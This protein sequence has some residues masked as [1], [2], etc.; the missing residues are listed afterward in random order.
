MIYNSPTGVN[1]FW[2]KWQR[3]N[4]VET[5]YD[6]TKFID[7]PSGKAFVGRV[8]PERYTYYYHTLE[9]EYIV[10]D[11][12]T[13]CPPN[14]R[15][16]SKVYRIGSDTDVPDLVKLVPAALGA[17]IDKIYLLTI[18][19]KVK[20]PT[21]KALF[22]SG[23]H[24]REP[25]GVTSLIAY[26]DYIISTP[27]NKALDNWS[28]NVVLLMN[29]LGYFIDNNRTYQLKKEINNVEG[30][31]HRKNDRNIKVF[32]LAKLKDPVAISRVVHREVQE[33]GRCGADIPS[34]LELVH[35]QPRAVG[36]VGVDLNRNSG[37]EFQLNG[38]KYTGWVK[39]LDREVYSGTEANSE[40]ETQIFQQIFREVSPDLFIT[41]HSYG[42]MIVTS[43]VYDD[44][45]QQQQQVIK[46]NKAN[47]VPSCYTLSGLIRDIPFYQGIVKDIKIKDV[48]LGKRSTGEYVR[49]PMEVS[50]LGT[51]TGDMTFWSYCYYQN[52]KRTKPYCGFT[53]ELGSNGEDGFYPDKYQM[54]DIV[55]NA[56]TILQNS[57]NTF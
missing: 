36:I 54:I 41:I 34:K 13:R 1:L 53:L 19:S 11:W 12:K 38:K 45:A 57:L 4:L 47:N 2:S 52:Q 14:V 46:F 51:A 32:N 27:D 43:D 44:G 21:K 28:L 49:F 56:F 6:E 7:K 26:I 31:Y 15:L 40:R 42:N 55:C 16:T 17:K 23:T 25:A 29:P 35:S 48:S 20:N 37:M 33:R 8:V 30:V 39:L 3:K 24:A 22:I 9:I 10:Q 18:E 50:P 5:S